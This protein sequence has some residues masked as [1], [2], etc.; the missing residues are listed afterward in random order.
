MTNLLVGDFIDFIFL[1]SFVVGIGIPFLPSTRADKALFH[2]H[3]TQLF[4]DLS[5]PFSL[6]CG[7]LV[8][9]FFVKTSFVAYFIVSKFTVGCSLAVKS[10]YLKSLSLSSCVLVP[11]NSFASVRYFYLAFISFF[12]SFWPALAICLPWICNYFL[13]LVTYSLDKSVL[14]PGFCSVFLLELPHFLLLLKFFDL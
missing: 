11:A 3:S 8:V 14:F 4:Y 5:F 2:Y 10:L 12:T 7:Y 6:F 1:K 9:K 13:L